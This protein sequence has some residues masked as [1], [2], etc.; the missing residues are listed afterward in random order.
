MKKH[1]LWK[2]A[3]L[4][5]SGVMVFSG[6]MLQPASALKSSTIV[7]SLEQAQAEQTI[8]F[9][10][11][12][13]QYTFS[14]LNFEKKSAP[15]YKLDADEQCMT[16]QYQV[17]N[18]GKTDSAFTAITLLTLKDPADN[19]YG[20]TLPEGKNSLNGVLKPGKS[21]IGYVRFTVSRQV[22]QYRLQVKPDLNQSS[23]AFLNLS[24]E[25][26]EL[27][28][29]IQESVPKQSANKQLEKAITHMTATIKAQ[30]GSFVVLSGLNYTVEKASIEAIEGKTC[31]VLTLKLESTSKTQKAITATS[32]F[33]LVDENGKTYNL[34]LPEPKDSLNG[35]LDPGK[36]MN[37]KLIFE[38]PKGKATFSLIIKT[39]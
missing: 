18:L 2:A 35:L 27:D 19:L 30:K 11:N 16:M 37:G 24:K 8:R 14:E 13:I 21:Q 33:N 26:F 28:T 15:K 1:W 23:C 20:L 22:G 17:T 7:N 4:G 10:L 38:V 5:I 29:L 6:V 32:Q 9:K 34:R 12:D 3:A 36:T 39:V 25:G 31:A